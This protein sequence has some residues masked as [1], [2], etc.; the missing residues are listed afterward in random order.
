MAR[1]T[2]R[3]LLATSS[4]AATPSTHAARQP[5][6]QSCRRPISRKQPSLMR[7]GTYTVFIAF[8][9][10][11]P[12]GVRMITSPFTYAVCHR[13][14]SLCGGRRLSIV[15]RAFSPRGKER[16]R[17]TP[18]IGKGAGNLTNVPVGAVRLKGRPYGR[19]GLP[20]P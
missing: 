4:G 6:R 19:G 7:T 14:P 2:A 5:A 17:T 13:P 11:V 8:Y 10:G 3:K 16:P 15:A 9:G 1:P 20:S 18:I 12:F